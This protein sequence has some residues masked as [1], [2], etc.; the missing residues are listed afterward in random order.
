MKRGAEQGRH[1]EAEGRGGGRP[2][3]VACRMVLAVALARRELG[4]WTARAGCIPHPEAR[5]QALGSLAHKAFHSL[6]A[7]VFG[8]AVPGRRLAPMVAFCVAYQTLSDY[9]DNWCDRSLPLTASRRRR[10]H[11]AMVAAL[12]PLPGPLRLAQPPADDGGYLD[13]L[14]AACRRALA[15][16]GP[17]PA[18]LRPARELARAYACMQARKHAEPG[19]RRHLTGRWAARLAAGRAGL[20]PAPGLAWWEVAAAAGSTLGVFA[21]VAAGARPLSPRAREAVLRAYFPWIAAWHIMLD[22]AVDR[23][24]DRQA[25]ELN[26]AACYPR[27]AAMLDRLHF[28]FRRARAAASALW[29]PAFHR[30]VVA[31]MGALY[32]CDPKARPLAPLWDRLTA[33]DPWVGRLRP[34]LGWW[35]AHH[36]APPQVAP[37]KRP[38]PAPA[39]AG[40]GAGE[41]APANPRP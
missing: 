10:L 19:R 26:F 29:E 6:G 7:A 1:Q 20:P 40:G 37:L 24:E 38:A 34:L 36:V 18:V 28:L 41:S 2:A 9:L 15:A 22:Y 14:V 13:E 17:D 21:L 4:R 12:E 3:A 11:Q 5:R 8:A 16:V 32:L 30:L 25:G 33:D 35:Q 23:A 39:G 31:G 27:P